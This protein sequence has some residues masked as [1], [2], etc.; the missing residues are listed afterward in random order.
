MIYSLRV[1]PY[2]MDDDSQEKGL[3]QLHDVSLQL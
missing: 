2:V 1:T 3:L